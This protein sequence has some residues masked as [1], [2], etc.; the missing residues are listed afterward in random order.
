MVVN[1]VLDDLELTKTAVSKALL[2]VAGPKLQE[3]VTANANANVKWG[4]I[5]KTEGCQLE[6]MFVYHAL[7]PSYAND[8]GLKVWLRH[9]VC[10][11]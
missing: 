4:D 2:A 5:V 6:S 7:A 10:W 9:T 1:T 3:H 8:S 11:Q